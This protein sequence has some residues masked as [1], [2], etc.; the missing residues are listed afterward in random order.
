MVGNLRINVTST[1]FIDSNL[2]AALEAIILLEKKH[3][4]KKRGILVIQQI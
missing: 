1:Y 3:L 4:E 2:K